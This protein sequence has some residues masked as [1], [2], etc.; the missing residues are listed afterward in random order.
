Y[1]LLDMKKVKEFSIEFIEDINEFS[2]DEMSNILG[3][4]S[5]SDSCWCIFFNNGCNKNTPEEE[6]DTQCNRN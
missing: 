1:I 3:G 2:N 6:P 4:T 5:S